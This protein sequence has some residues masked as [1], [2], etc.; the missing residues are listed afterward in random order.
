MP[1]AKSIL[2]VE[3]NPDDELLAV[4]A[5]KKNNLDTGL[6]V[7]RNG[8]EA[9]ELLLGSAQPLP[10]LVLLDLNLPKVNGLEVLERLRAS[11]RTKALPVV[12]LTSS[13]EDHDIIR[14]YALGAN[15]YVRKPIELAQFVEAVRTLSTFWLE[16]NEVPPAVRA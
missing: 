6:I 12:V 2:L 15:A 14:S 10:Q 9:L 1:S 8:E 4:R 3:D 7:A 16:M 13:R 11:E 5:M